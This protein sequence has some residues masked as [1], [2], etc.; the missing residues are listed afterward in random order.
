MSDGAKT[1]G[2][3]ELATVRAAA[4]IGLR[5]R[6]AGVRD[7]GLLVGLEAA[8]LGSETMASVLAEAEPQRFRAYALVSIDQRVARWLGFDCG[9][10]QSQSGAR[11]RL[12]LGDGRTVT[13]ATEALKEVTL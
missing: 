10:V 8:L 4:R 1:V 5:L 12:L 7:A 9:L 3:S 2:Y 6:F 13:V 11:T